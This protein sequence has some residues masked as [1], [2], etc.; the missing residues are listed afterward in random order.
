[1]SLYNRI[2]EQVT[3]LNIY[4][5]RF[6]R[7]KSFPPKEFK[8]HHISPR[9]ALFQRFCERAAPLKAPR[10]RVVAAS[11]FSLKSEHDRARSMRAKACTQKVWNI[12]VRQS[13]KET[14]IDNKTDFQTAN[15]FQLPHPFC[16]LASWI[17]SSFVSDTVLS[18]YKDEVFDSV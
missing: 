4:T 5:K 1:M 10:V 7:Q 3:V 13:K 14:G 12:G 17:P 15:K 9:I 18:R 2:S 6:I 16:P 8:R 11:I